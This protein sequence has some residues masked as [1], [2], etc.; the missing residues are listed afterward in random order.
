M[1]QLNS[2]PYTC[3]TGGS[4]FP[5]EFVIQGNVPS[6]NYV[7]NFAAGA[8]RALTTEVDDTDAITISIAQSGDPMV[9]DDHGSVAVTTLGKALPNT[10]VDVLA[11][12]ASGALVGLAGLALIAV[13][14]LRRRTRA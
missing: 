14:V 2:G 9:F 13:A 3:T 7:V 6:D 4:D 12:V 11:T 8:F 5:F 1:P 10:G